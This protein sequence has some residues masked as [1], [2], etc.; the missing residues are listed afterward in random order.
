MV[1]VQISDLHVGAGAAGD[2]ERDLVDA[3]AAIATLTPRPDA[4]L[5]TGDLAEHGAPAEYERV[6]TLLDAIDAPVLRSPATTTTALR[7]APRFR[8][9]SREP[10][11]PV[12]GTHCATASASVRCVVVCDTALPGRGD[13]ALDSEQRTWLQRELAADLAT[14]TI[15]AMRDP[16]AP[17]GLPFLD[18]HLGQA[19]L[20]LDD[21]PA[22]VIM[23]LLV[24]G[25]LVS[26]V[27]ALGTAREVDASDPTERAERAWIHASSDCR[28]RPCRTIA[29]S[30]CAT[31]HRRPNGSCAQGKP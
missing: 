20:E 7:C 9:P 17:I 2:P 8:R 16:P 22:G 27:Q 3:V 25:E 6:L 11:S 24:D 31:G 13:G 18:V 30:G 14:P 19:G 21:Q 5:V 29:R 23:H 1:L 10:A 4:V 15:V 26:H 12:G 28:R